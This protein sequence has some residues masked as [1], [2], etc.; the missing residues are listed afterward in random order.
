MSLGVWMWDLVFFSFFLFCY[1][2]E[3]REQTAGEDEW[4]EE[5]AVRRCGQ[6]TGLVFLGSLAG[7]LYCFDM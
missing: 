4:L 3:W 1:D 6:S 7:L 5:M 2:E